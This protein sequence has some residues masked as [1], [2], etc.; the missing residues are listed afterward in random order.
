[1][2]NMDIT[3]LLV[4]STVVLFVW[5]TVLTALFARQQQFFRSLSKGV[6][7]KDLLSILKQLLKS[8]ENASTKIET[9]EN[10]ITEI[11]KKSHS[12]LQKMGF[13][14]FNPFGDTGGDQSFCLCLLDQDNNG[15]VVTSLHSRQSTRIYAKLVTSSTFRREDFSE[16]ETRSY[17]EAKK[18]SQ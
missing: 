14:R 17:Q 15:I 12:Y 3:P 9:N 6:V 1:M 4:V 5:S 13:V 18:E 11:Q 8:L 10:A 2:N 16:E 7:K